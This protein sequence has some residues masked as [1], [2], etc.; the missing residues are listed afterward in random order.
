MVPSLKMIR[1]ER[2]LDKL[3][4][5]FISPKREEQVAGRGVAMRGAQVAT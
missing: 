4:M 1:F 3:T 2:G 5:S